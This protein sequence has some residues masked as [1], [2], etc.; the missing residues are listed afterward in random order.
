MD[1][2]NIPGGTDYGLIDPEDVNEQS[3]NSQS[4]DSNTNY[5]PN[6]PT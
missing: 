2:E 3:D 4:N 1:K 6:N 5:D